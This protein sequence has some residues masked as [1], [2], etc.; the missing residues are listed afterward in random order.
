MKK[1]FLLIQVITLFSCSPSIRTF[2]ENKNQPLNPNAKIYVIALNE[3]FN[4]SAQKIAHLEIGETGFTSKCDYDD[5]IKQAKL[6]AKEFGANVIK[7]TKHQY[8]EGTRSGCHRI[9]VDFY[10]TENTT[11]LEQN[12]PQNQQKNETWEYSLLYIYR[13][14]GYGNEIS[15]DLY[16]DNKK[17]H[18]IP[19]SFKTIVKIPKEGVQKLTAK[20][21]YYQTEL[22]LDFENGNEYFLECEVTLEPMAGAPRLKLKD[23]QTGKH[24]FSNFI[25]KNIY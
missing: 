10:F 24:V 15:F 22:N 13:T 19:N 9:D 1:L 4:M 20:T 5:V 6:K 16:L 14:H 7:V 8:P 21:R 3:T 17:L 18:S 12:H 11:E 2:V 23:Y 25:S